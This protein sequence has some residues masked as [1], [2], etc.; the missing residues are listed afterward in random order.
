[1]DDTFKKGVIN[2]NKSSYHRQGSHQEELSDSERQVLQTSYHL[3]HPEDSEETRREAAVKEMRYPPLFTDHFSKGKCLL[4]EDSLKF[5]VTIQ[6]NKSFKPNKLHIIIERD[7]NYPI[8]EVYVCKN[9]S[10]VESFYKLG[11]INSPDASYLVLGTRILKIP[12]EMVTMTLAAPHSDKYA[13]CTNGKVGLNRTKC[14]CGCFVGL[15]AFKGQV[16]ITVIAEKEIIHQSP[17][18]VTHKATI[19]SA[20]ELEPISIQT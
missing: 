17:N 5:S 11:K 7:E 14:D 13:Q 8:F 10:K 20:G 4:C 1:M 18:G 19:V 3:T 6:T 16:E 15:Y 12:S 9:H 2:L